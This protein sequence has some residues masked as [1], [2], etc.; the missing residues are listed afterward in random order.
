MGETER[1]ITVRVGTVSSEREYFYATSEEQVTQSR[2][3]IK[4]RRL[5]GQK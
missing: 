3:T 2:T 5:N 1:V 4:Q